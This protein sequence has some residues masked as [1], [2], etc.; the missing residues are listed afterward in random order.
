MTTYPKGCFRNASAP[1]APLKLRPIYKDNWDEFSDQPAADQAFQWIKEVCLPDACE[2][3]IYDA[4]GQYIYIASQPDI[5]SR[6][7]A[8]FATADTG[9]KCS[10]WEFPSAI[11]DANYTPRPFID[12]YSEGQPHKLM[13]RQITTTAG[14]TGTPLGGLIWVAA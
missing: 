4:S 11:F 7:V 14:V 8:G 1:G 3:G 6:V 2:M 12:Q 5:R 13:V 9:A 10:I